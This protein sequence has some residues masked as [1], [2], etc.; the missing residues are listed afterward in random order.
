MKSLR[1]KLSKSQ[2]GGLDNVVAT[3]DGAVTTAMD[4]DAAFRVYTEIS[5][6]VVEINNVLADRTWEA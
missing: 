1:P 4:A 3:I 5:G 6:F 2:Q